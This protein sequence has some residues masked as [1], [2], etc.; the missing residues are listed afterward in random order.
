MNDREPKTFL[1]ILCDPFGF[2]FDDDLNDP[3]PVN[4]DDSDEEDSE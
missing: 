4:D 2:L 3:V 1:D